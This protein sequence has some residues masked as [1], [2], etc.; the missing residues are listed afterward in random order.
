MEI[1]DMVLARDNE[2]CCF[3]G[4]S[5]EKEGV[6]LDVH[7]IRPR[8]QGGTDT[9]DNLIT[10]CAHCHS[11]ISRPK[12]YAAPLWHVIGNLF[13]VQQNYGEPVN[14]PA[15]NL[16]MAICRQDSLFANDKGEIAVK[17]EKVAAATNNLL[18]VIARLRNV[19]ALS[20]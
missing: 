6:R 20:S 2:C 5:N 13:Y 16:L 1:R 12:F 11:R 8:R 14:R 10:L 15:N 7:H 9:L 18:Q 17:G 19:N 4:N 3:C